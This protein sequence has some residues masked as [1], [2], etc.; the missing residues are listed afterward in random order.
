[1]NLTIFN[2]YLVN[3]DSYHGPKS[4]LYMYM[5][6]MYVCMHVCMYVQS[7]TILQTITSKIN[8]FFYFNYVLKFLMPFITPTVY[9]LSFLSNDKKS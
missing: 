2:F 9:S 1:M 5:H 8:F 3:C 7:V 6:R 4:V